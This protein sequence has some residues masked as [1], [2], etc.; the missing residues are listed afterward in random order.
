MI[1]VSMKRVIAIGFATA[2]TVVGD[3]GSANA[4]ATM[5]VGQMLDE[6]YDL[7]CASHAAVAIRFV[8]GDVDLRNRIM[9]TSMFYQ[10][11]LSGRDGLT[12]WT[13]VI[14]QRALA[15]REGKDAAFGAVTKCTHHMSDVVLRKSAQ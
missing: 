8:E 2:L 4:A 9:I 13:E 10:G 6:R 5:T 11:R 1:G 7:E 12:N 3:H 14:R 15:S